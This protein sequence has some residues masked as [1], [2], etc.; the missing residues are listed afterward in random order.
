MAIPFPDTFLLPL[1]A[2]PLIYWA[3]NLRKQTKLVFYVHDYL[4]GYD[5]SAITVAGKDGPQTSVLHFGTMVA[6]DDP[7]TEGPDPKSKVIGRSHGM[8]IN[9]Q[10]DGKG[11]HLVFSVIFTDG[12]YKGSTLEIQGAD[13]FAMKEREFSIVSGTGY[14]RFVRGYGIM[15]TQFIDIPNLRAIL[16]LDVTVKHY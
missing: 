16:K 1:L 13:L 3:F 14:F 15:T 4:S 11:L 10:L 9:S 8:Y 5:T 7:V 6:V 12:E 2:L